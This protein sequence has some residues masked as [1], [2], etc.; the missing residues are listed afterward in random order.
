M[1]TSRSTITLTLGMLAV[2]LA[3]CDDGTGIESLDDQMT[4]DAALLAADATLEEVAMFREPV[5]F[6]GL[7]IPGVDEKPEHRHRPGRPGGPGSFQ[8]EL[9][10][11]RAVSFYDASGVEQDEYDEA[12]TASVHILHDVAGSIERDRFTAEI[13]RERDMVV[14]G[15]EGEE[16][17]RTWNGSGSSSMLRSGVREDGTERSHSSEGSF[18]Y[19]DVVVP[20]PGTEER[21][22]ISGTISRTMVMTRTGPDGSETREV[23]IEIIFDGTSIASAVVNGEVMEI[24]LTARERQHPMHRRRPGG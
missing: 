3:A 19:T 1:R 21:W 8:G 5:G 22:P 15:L 13:S 11:T 14:S 24:D 4:L 6:R 18:T 16:T 7:H 2:G 17:H 23:E 12:A 20:I 9:S 10:G